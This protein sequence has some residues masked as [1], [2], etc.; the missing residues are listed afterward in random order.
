MVT[1][2]F[3]APVRGKLGDD[4]DPAEKWENVEKG[5]A[6]GRKIRA[7]FPCSLDLFI[8]HEHEELV[9][10]F[11]KNGMV[12]EEVLAACCDIA[13]SKDF[14]IVYD[15]DGISSGMQR[16]IDAMSA[17]GKTIVYIDD[18]DEEAREEIALVVN[19]LRKE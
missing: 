18:V 1:A 5:I 15:A 6:I 7:L 8:P 9:E 11:I 16:E 4:V 19:E 3:M 12:S 17:A 14:A 10:A 2:Y 13:L